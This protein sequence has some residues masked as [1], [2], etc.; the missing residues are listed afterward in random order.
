MSFLRFSSLLYLNHPSFL[1]FLSQFSVMQA[2]LSL[3]FVF[4][5]RPF[6]LYS[7]IVSK[8]PKLQVVVALKVFSPWRMKK[9]CVKKKMI[10]INF[11]KLPQTQLLVRKGYL[12]LSSVQRVVNLLLLPLA[13]GDDAVIFRN[14]LA[15]EA[16]NPLALHGFQ[17]ERVVRTAN[18]LGQ[19]LGHA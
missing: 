12:G 6:S 15:L 11:A 7:S 3:C 19:V 4:M 5:Q 10:N 16:G 14:L 1:T 2:P 17:A 8:V 9:I 18:F 13:T